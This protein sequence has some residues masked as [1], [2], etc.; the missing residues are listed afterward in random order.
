MDIKENKKEYLFSLFIGLTLVLLWFGVTKPMITIKLNS[1]VDAGIS[2]FNS[3]VID[4]TRSIWGTVVELHEKDRTLVAFLIFFF[5][6]V[7][8]ILKSVLFLIALYVKDRKQGIKKILGIISKWSMA[9]VFVVAIFLA[10]L[11]TDGQL[12]VRKQTLK[13]FGMSLTIKVSAFMQ[14]TL[15]RGFYYF[16]GYCIISLLIF[17]AWNYL[18]KKDLP[19]V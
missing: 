9:D 1:A 3:T 7:I 15:E 5:S 11:A 17:Q 12:E 13:V 16:L 10:F 14:T 18:D 19:R 4:T 2:K 6:V 8:P